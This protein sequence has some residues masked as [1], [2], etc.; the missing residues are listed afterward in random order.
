MDILGYKK[1]KEMIKNGLV[2]FLV[3]LYNNID[4]DLK[5]LSQFAS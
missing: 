2:Q 1:I 4:I 5:C 3:A